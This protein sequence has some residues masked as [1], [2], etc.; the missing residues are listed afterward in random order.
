M[1]LITTHINADFDALGSLV[2]AKKLYPNS[3]LM[4]PGSQ[5]KAVREFLS[6]A[7]ELVVFESERECRLYDVTRL[8]LVDTRHK[9]RIGIAAELIDKGVEVHAYDHHPK[10]KDDIV[11]DKDIY[12][13][14]GA[15]VTILADIIK[16]KGFRVTPLE[17]TI[18]LL[19]IYEETGSL[20]YRVTTKL[21]VDM[22]SFLLSKGANLSM[23][24]SYLNRELSEGELA[25]LT[26]F[27]SIT[28]KIEIKGVSISIA[29][30]DSQSYTGELGTIIHKLT[31]IENIPVLFVLISSQH[32][33]VDIIGRS[34]VPTVD[35]NKILAHFGGGGHPGAAA[36]KVHGRDVAFV[37][38]ALINILEK[39]IKLHIRAKDIM[40]R[41]VRTMSPNVKIDDAR[42]ILL[43]ERLGGMPVIVRGRVV[44]VI[45]LEGLN[46]AIKRGF[47]HSRIK[48]Y[49]SG[50]VVTVTPQTP[51]YIIQKAVMDEDA[52]VIPVLKGRRLAGVINRTKVMQNVY[53]ASF[54]VPSEVRKNITS[55][56]SKKMSAILPKDIMGLLKKIGREGNSRGYSVFVVGGLVR[57]LMLGAKNLDL[58]IVVEGD[59]I[60]LGHVIAKKLDAAL[61]IHRRFGTCSVVTKGRLKIDLATARKEV[62]ERPAALPTVEFSSLKD[63]LV[64]RD[65]TINAMAVSLNKPSFGQLVDFFG[66]ERDLSSA[67][68]RVMHDASFIDDP[69]RI[70][71]A[72][73]FEQRFG[74]KIDNHTE[75][76]VKHAIKIEMFDKVE[77]QRIRDEIILILKEDEPF[78]ALSR[79]AQLDELR[80]LHPNIKLNEKMVRLYKNIEEACRWYNDSSF[81]KRAIDIWL[82]YFMA[83]LGNLSYNDV[84]KICDRFVFRKGERLRILSYK[85]HAARVTK[86]LATGSGSL[87]PSRTY[88]ILEPLSFEV[89]LLIMA[90]TASRA[91]KSRVRD[92]Y[93]KYN[94]VKTSVRGEDL[95]AMG[96][97]PCPDYKVILNRVLCAKIDG[98]LK[99]RKEEIIYTKRLI[100]RI[101]A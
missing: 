90:G 20:T 95:K 53:D 54:S 10:T 84:S 78:K 98:K 39:N 21:D 19:G 32:D 70:F 16:R 58:D 11:A 100:E 62:Y 92:F 46:K 2:A 82:I 67:R 48:G 72:V 55:N 15:T 89:I 30:I 29:E 51:L 50:R 99:T 14:V 42:E 81:K 80:F 3:R 18:M 27:I 13:E 44:G 64:R 57:D 97:R 52:G 35:A 63:D 68:I 5:E 60:K 40:S 36:A 41:N 47:G 34:S 91:A 37:R 74:F 33:R 17:A 87:E 23:V 101:Y 71:R 69:T 26:K 49:M 4:L 38:N 61:V 73:R 77:P 6:L 12:E 85:K 31:E 45:T 96:L 79:M 8:V 7:K 24:S 59:A 66:G 75:D 25:L 9:S 88:T 28:K 83:M 76:L 93:R 1:D 94:G 56:I 86:A 43:K 65:F 22:V